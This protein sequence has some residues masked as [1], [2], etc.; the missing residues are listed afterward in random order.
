LS[1]LLEQLRAGLSTTYDFER[2]LGG[3]GMSRVFVA[4]ETALSR[5][6]VV[7]VVA[8]GLLEGLSAD[9][10]TREVKVAA[11]LQ[12]ANIVPLLSA[13]ETNGVPY[14]TMPFVDGLSLRARIASGSPVSIAEATSILR[15]VGK[16]LAYAHGHGVVHRDIKPDNVLL[17]GGTAMVTDFGIAKALTVSRTEDGLGTGITQVGT[18]IGTPAYM[19]PEQAAG[20]PNV[21]H[22]ADLYAWGV[23]AWELITGRHPFAACTTPATLVRAQLAEVPPTLASVRAETPAALSVLVARCLEKDPARRPQSANE[24][25]EALDH[26]GEGRGAS[27]ITATQRTAA[28]A[29]GIVILV[30]GGVWMSKGS[31][32]TSTPTTPKSLAV[33][34]F[35]SVGGDTA[36]TYFAEGIADELTT[37][38]SKTAGLRVAATSSAFSYRNKTADVRDVAK[39]LNVGAVLQGRVRREGAKMRVSAQLTNASDGLVI[40][41]DS[42]ERE[43]K[44]VFAV[45]SEIT[46]NIVGALRV[47]LAAGPVPKRDTTDVE[48][49]DLYLR[50]LSVLQ[51]RGPGVGRSIGYFKRALERDS[52]FAPAWGELGSAYSVLPLFSPVPVDSVIGLARV[53]IAKARALNPNA[54][55]SYA[56]EGLVSL[57]ALQWQPANVAFARAIELDSSYTLAHRAYTSSLY[58]TGRADEAIAQ[59]RRA[60]RLDPLSSTT[61]AVATVVLLNSGRFDDA[62]TMARRAN[63]L[64][65]SAAFPRLVFA[66]SMYA[67]GKTDSARTLLEGTRPVPQSAAWFGYLLS[68]T[69]DRAGAAAFLKTL[70]AERGQ[71][72]FVNVSEAWTFLGAGDTTRALAALERALQAREP[73]AFAVPFGMPAYDAIR[74][75]ARFAAVITG[76]GLDPALFRTPR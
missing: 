72:A 74:R 7:K 49:Y 46:R 69:G 60:A 71:N 16:A 48:T 29:A 75:S 22:R 44:D 41:S 32:S 67:S 55:A 23:M 36:N 15:D 65:P 6:V 19:A 14:Y 11:R 64:D 4:T 56:A 52:N 18:S 5:T 66:L 20:D 61:H 37:A 24:L 57:L 9:R 10:F 45:Q 26:V 73:I 35:E 51:A 1:D 28:I 3:G 50:G 59:G 13:G 76:Y 42:Y 21:D 43:V 40:W 62:L 31:S 58:Q 63:E 54:P 68:A 12:Q 70:A 47:T 39:A 30:A 27:R 25:L 38:L 17:S 33:L 8:T 53:A 34:P 2:E